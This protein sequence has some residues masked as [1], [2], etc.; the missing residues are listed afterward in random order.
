MNLNYV[1]PLHHSLLGVLVLSSQLDFKLTVMV[2]ALF[3]IY[4]KYVTGT[5][6]LNK[7]VVEDKSARKIG[8]K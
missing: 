2:H 7:A 6:I 1:K 8:S 4:I 5:E 3:S